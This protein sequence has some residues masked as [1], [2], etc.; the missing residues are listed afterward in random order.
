[1]HDRLLAALGDMPGAERM[2]IPP[3]V[4]RGMG[5]EFVAFDR[6]AGTIRSRWPLENRYRG[7]RGYLQGGILTTLFDNTFGPLAYLAGEGLFVSLDLRTTFIRSVGPEE[8]SV[9]IAA[10]LVERTRRF[11]L[12]RGEAFRTDGTR[13]ALCDSR[14]VELASPG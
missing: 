12:V 8:T 7:P 2:E 3:P 11:L 1:M 14:L 10:E 9:E 6:E 13:V 5:G 4:F